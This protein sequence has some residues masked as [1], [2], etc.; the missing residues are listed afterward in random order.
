MT[1]VRDESNPTPSYRMTRREL[2]VASAGVTAGALL[3]SAPAVVLAQSAAPVVPAGSDIKIGV[4][5][6]FTG[7]FSGF[8][9]MQRSGYLLAL[10]Q[11][12]NSAGGPLAWITSASIC[13]CSLAGGVG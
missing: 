3:A 8:G 12:N 13:C 11:A 5:S 2:L 1:T 7:V 4:L 6:A 10:D 9:S